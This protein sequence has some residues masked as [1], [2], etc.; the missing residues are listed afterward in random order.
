MF[1]ERDRDGCIAHFSHE[2]EAVLASRRRHHGAFDGLDD[3]QP[4]RMTRPICE[5]QQPQYSR[6][7]SLH[8][9]RVA[10]TFVAEKQN[11]GNQGARVDD[12]VPAFG[13]AA[14]YW[15]IK[16][17]GWVPTLGRYVGAAAVEEGDLPVAERMALQQ[18]TLEQH[19][20]RAEEQA[21]RIQVR[22]TDEF[23]P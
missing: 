19:N 17:N 13:K 8:P 1:Q 12:D 20:K 7:G 23:D 9:R 18:A 10:Q 14:T 5:K 4:R 21:A 3:A 6:C 15:E 22:L 2:D 16:A 11:A